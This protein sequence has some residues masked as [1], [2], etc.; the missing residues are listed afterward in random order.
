MRNP[1]LTEG[2]MRGGTGMV[3]P[4]TSTKRPLCPPPMN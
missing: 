4:L 1:A 2:N 3:Y